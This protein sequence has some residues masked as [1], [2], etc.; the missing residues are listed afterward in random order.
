M[1]SPRTVLIIEDD[2]AIQTLLAAI[3][4]RSNLATDV[5]SNGREALT[6]LTSRHYDVA[7]LDL[8]MPCVDGYE[9]LACLERMAP[10]LLERMIVL[11]AVSPRAIDEHLIAKLAFRVLHKPFEIDQL[12]TTIHDCLRAQMYGRLAHASSKANAYGAVV[13]VVDATREALDLVWS[14]GYREGVVASVNPLALTRST[15]F[16]MSIVEAQPVW[17]HSREELAS[18]FAALLPTVQTSGSHAIAAV[19]FLHNGVV[20]GSIGWSFDAPQSFDA[21]HQEQLRQIAED[22]GAAMG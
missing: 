4:R 7:I 3:L 15:P 18:S 16:G 22:Y 8:L 1:A 9:V 11:S 5:V 13:G 14:F 12:I 10:H 17:V 21:A 19:P 6:A 20:T 2:P